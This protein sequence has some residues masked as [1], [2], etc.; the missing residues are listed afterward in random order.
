M[1]IKPKKLKR[2][3]ETKIAR[4]PAKSPLLK[5]PEMTKDPKKK[6]KKHK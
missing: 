3:K 5:T 1:P 6:Q 2:T 4:M